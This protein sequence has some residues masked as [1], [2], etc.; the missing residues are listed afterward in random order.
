MLKGSKLLSAYLARFKLKGDY[1]RWGLVEVH[2]EKQFLIK[3]RTP[4]RKSN[5]R[6]AGAGTN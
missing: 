5:D 3:K 2:Q 1:V 4:T 6:E